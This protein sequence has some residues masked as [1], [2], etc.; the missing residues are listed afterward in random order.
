VARI[1]AGKPPL[2]TV[3]DRAEAM[4]LHG[5]ILAREK[6]LDAISAQVLTNANGGN[7]YT[8][9]T[10]W[11]SRIANADSFGQ[12]VVE[13]TPG[14]FKR[15]YEDVK[16]LVGAAYDRIT[17]APREPVVAKTPA[18][19]RQ[20]RIVER[21]QWLER[22]LQRISD[23]A[24]VARL[25][26]NEFGTNVVPDATV[27]LATG[28]AAGLAAR[29]ALAARNAFLAARAAKMLEA[30]G[31]FAPGGNAAAEVAALRGK[32]IPLDDG[33]QLLGPEAALKGQA[34]N[35]TTDNLLAVNGNGA[36]VIGVHSTADSLSFYGDVAGTQTLGVRNVAVGA[37]KAGYRGG[38]LVLNA[39]EC[40]QNASLV[41]GVFQ[42]LKQLENNGRLT[43]PVGRIWAP[44]ESVTGEGMLV[45]AQGNV[46]EG[47]TWQLVHP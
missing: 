43:K 40:A 9:L 13:S 24:A 37:W 25:E 15:L 2:L 32:V 10:R 47:A 22:E 36:F 29:T 21:Q 5:T 27:A 45:D 33:R 35:L 6:E 34:V 42:E 38:D 3:R 19:E 44:S 4:A 16:G 1:N 14:G 28:P 30:G 39:C 41:K 11:G 23:G 8:A 12:G 31:T 18:E 17:G 46:I 26:G 20:A 7:S